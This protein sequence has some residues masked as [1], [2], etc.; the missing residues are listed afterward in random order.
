MAGQ[1]FSATNRCKDRLSTCHSSGHDDT[2]HRYRIDVVASSVADVVRSAGGW[3]YDRVMVGWDVNALLPHGRN[4]LPLQILGVKALDL[5]S[6]FASARERFA[7]HG[8]AVSAETFASDAR[9]RMKV[10]AALDCGLTKVVL[11][12]EGCPEQLE[13]QMRAAQHRLSAAA[14]AFKVQALAAAAIPEDSVDFAETFLCD[15]KTCLP[16]DS[17]MIP[18]RAEA[19]AEMSRPRAVL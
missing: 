17:D 14:R 12:G 8:L 3:L 9:V 1:V 10:L 7:G 2:C 16:V 19:Y 13:R 4:I 5:E 18:S 11:W 15:M 6:Q